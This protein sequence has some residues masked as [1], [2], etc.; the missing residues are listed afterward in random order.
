MAKS[1]F[2][3]FKNLLKSE[4]TSHPFSIGDEVV[5]KRPVSP[6]DGW[7]PKTGI[8]HAVKTE[9]GKHKVKV[10]YREGVEHPNHPGGGG[11]YA[12]WDH[13]G[14]WEKDLKKS[15]LAK[16]P[17]ITD[18]EPDF[19]ERKLSVMNFNPKIHHD[20]TTTEVEPG[21]F[22][23][24]YKDIG[25][26]TA[27]TH[28]LSH[29]DPKKP[30]SIIVGETN[31]K[32]DNQPSKYTALITAT[33]KD[34]QGKG[35][36]TKLKQLALNHHG[37][38]QSDAIV[39]PPEHDSWKRLGRQKGVM[40]NLGETLD[41]G[42]NEQDI[43]EASHSPH[44][45]KIKKAELA[46][47]PFPYK[48]SEREESEFEPHSSSS[49][50][51]DKRIPLP[52][53]MTYVRKK[54]TRPPG[55]H[56]LSWTHHHTLHDAD[57]DAIAEVRTK[58]SQV[59]PD[60][61]DSPSTH[62]IAWSQVHPDHKGM[63]Y[64]RK[65]MGAIAIHGTNGRP[66]SSD[67]NISPNAQKAWQSFFK[68]PGFGGKLAPY[69]TKGHMI[70][71]SPEKYGQSH[72]LFVRDKDK[73]INH[74]FG[75]QQEEKLA[76]SELE[77]GAKGDWKKE[78]YA[79]SHGEH[80]ISPNEF[81]P[82][83]FAKDREGKTVGYLAYE[84]GNKG[85]HPRGVEVNSEHRRKGIATE[86]YRH[87][88]KFSGGKFNRS[89]M[90][91]GD[92]KDLW[93]Q[94]NRPFGKSDLKK[95]SRP[96]I[97]FPGLSVN[98]RPDQEVS[99]IETGRQKDMWGR[100]A[101]NKRFGN[102]SRRRDMAAKRLSG[103]FDRNNLGLNVG[104]EGVDPSSAA[105]AGKARSKFEERSDEDQ[106]K[107]LDWSTKRN[108]LV[109]DY[110]KKYKNW[111]KMAYDL[112]N[113]PDKTA[114]NEHLGNRPEKPKLPR[115]P[116]KKRVATE[117]LSPEA[118]ASR[119]RSVDA[120]IE[121]EGLHHTMADVTNKYGSA[122][123][124]NLEG[125]LLTAYDPGTL[126][127]VA[128]YITARLGYKPSGRKFT[129][130]ILAHSR[131]I[132]VNPEKRKKFKEFV[133]ADAEKHVSNL[134]RGHQ[135]AYEIS[136]RIKPEDIGKAEGVRSPSKHI[137][138]NTLKQIKQDHN[139]AASGKEYSEEELNHEIN[140]RGQAQ[141]ER[142]ARQKRE[143]PSDKNRAD[144]SWMFSRG[145][146]MGLKKG[147]NG[148][149]KKEGYTF[150]S[151]KN[152]S[153]D[154]VRVDIHHPK[155][156]LVGRAEFD[157]DSN[158]EH[159]IPTGVNIHENHR[160]KGLASEAYRHAENFSNMK[161]EPSANQSSGAKALWAQPKRSFGK[162]DLEKIEKNKIKINLDHGRHI[163]NVYENAKHDPHH[164]DTK[165][166]YGAL[167]SETGKQFQ[168]LVN[169]GYKFSKIQP[170]QVN[171][172][173]T[174]RHMH[175]D[176]E[177]NKHLWYFPTEQGF[178]SSDASSKDHPM[179]GSSGVNHNGEDLMANDAFRIVH[180]INGHHVG[181][182]SGFGPAGEHK[183]Y[184]TH[185]KTFSPLAQRAL[186]TETLGQN[187]W[188]NF[189]EKHG[190]N[191]RANPQNTVYAEQKAFAMPENIVNGKWHE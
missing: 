73:A 100:K 136:Q 112:S 4:K 174:S 72:V 9:K 155:H 191:N 103:N 69:S 190:A 98:T 20:L 135:K 185:K 97:S 178:G 6:H 144:Y 117:D 33:H 183:A 125:Q 113:Q 168:D 80:E 108:A 32:E 166:A 22:H 14:Y 87:A 67:L 143:V 175:E 115:K 27:L 142:F 184:L 13:A 34:F 105:L 79:F 81:V 167:I 126:Q 107:L 2:H 118:M 145:G 47:A 148:D 48:P 60:S 40:V 187:S 71:Q 23:H 11:K 41:G 94:P 130:E 53:G 54:E 17:V 42:G 150:S 44:V 39:S 51:E 134:K 106:T 182:K 149:W 111:M 153:G 70:N 119:G 116:A 75:D 62:K 92:G 179:L 84:S 12:M 163:A 173:P 180:D 25:E 30:I 37:S 95:M 154:G 24:T 161:I 157:W 63:G 123:Q 15:E 18:Q 156:G 8:V 129:E 88:E 120:T 83:V 152:N 96:R 68:A 101:A 3:V 138:L 55:E 110:N 31:S 139:V 164:P 132:L 77:K 28:S 176:V 121:H 93:S 74:L 170:G 109:D 36:G 127:Q 137:P 86:L 76:A 140:A 61:E 169:Q 56:G 57:G 165:A 171:P 5:Q 181:G 50:I 177:K 89:Q 133:G 49:L 151:S 59:D 58:E 38:I 64:G 102:D 158:F 162:S 188:V 66:L 21:L 128:G 141:A 35:Y 10:K 104:I 82:A 122:A 26:E 45:A 7:K 43:I 147:Q 159:Y 99:L 85:L 29:G 160:R 78:G 46:K 186:A 131:D 91:T 52:G 65:L 114:Y 1:L 90:Q 146:A 124:K 16:A 189:S 172:Y 19:A